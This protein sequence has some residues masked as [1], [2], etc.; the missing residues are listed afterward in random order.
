MRGRV[1]VHQIA[2]HC[3]SFVSHIASPRRCD[4]EFRR[5]VAES[6][7]ERRIR[8]VCYSAASSVS[9]LRSR[10][11]LAFLREVPWLTWSLHATEVLNGGQQPSRIPAHY[12]HTLPTPRVPRNRLPLPRVAPRM[13]RRFAFHE[14][15]SPCQLF[16]RNPATICVRSTLAMNDLSRCPSAAVTSPEF[17]FEASFHLR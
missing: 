7:Q 1:R 5:S 2:T 3:G 4:R 16:F 14:S 13:A 8:L 11:D 15:H 6:T 9:A 17:R 10:F 12:C